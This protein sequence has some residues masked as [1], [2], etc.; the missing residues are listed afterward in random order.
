M[1]ERNLLEE[2]KYLYESMR[3]DND[4]FI[5]VMLNMKETLDTM[6][7][8]VSEL[9]ED[10]HRL[11][12]QL[13]IIY[14][15]QLGNDLY[16]R[17]EM[18]RTSN[19]ERELENFINEPEPQINVESELIIPRYSIP[20]HIRNQYINSLDDHQQICS[21]CVQRVENNNTMELTEC[22]HLF[23]SDCLRLHNTGNDNANCPICHREL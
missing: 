22:G 3:R 17:R 18:L 6:K 11:R 8:I 14:H 16:E 20:P 21:I 1:S 12:S 15:Q 10:N 5:Q 19:S 2:Y 13:S 23:H 7:E 4:K 9:K